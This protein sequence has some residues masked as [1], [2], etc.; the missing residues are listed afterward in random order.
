MNRLFDLSEWDK[1]IC[2]LI[3]NFALQL[4]ML[5]IT[6][7]MISN[8]VQPFDQHFSPGSQV[9]M[10]VLEAMG[11]SS[12]ENY[13]INQ[14]TLDLAFPVVYSFGYAFLII[15][16]IKLSQFSSSYI[17]Y[18]SLIPFGI[19]FFD[20][21]ENTSIVY[22][23][24]R[25]PDVTPFIHLLLSSANPLKHLLTLTTGLGLLLLFAHLLYSRNQKHPK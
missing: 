18:F 12:R 3:I 22:T 6:Y 16:L 7:P 4:C 19:A 20:L 23:L 15:Q 24:V 9:I 11:E 21:I 1:V 25:F 2:F 8:S 13:L 14:L 10:G 17:N 5:L